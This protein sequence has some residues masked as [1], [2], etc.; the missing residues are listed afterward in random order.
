MI[1]LPHE[2]ILPWRGSS[3]PH[4]HQQPQQEGRKK[5]PGQHQ[6]TLRAHNDQ[7]PIQLQGDFEVDFLY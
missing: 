6:P 5:H 4:Q 7:R 3:R 1:P 2:G